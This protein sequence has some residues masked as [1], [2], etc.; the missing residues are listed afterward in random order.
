MESMA[1]SVFQ[2]TGSN[3]RFRSVINLDISTVAYRPL[4]GKSFI[5]LP[6]EL[7][8]KKAVIKMNNTD[9]HCFKWCV[10]RAKS[11]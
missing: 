7:A 1:V 11:C 8:N 9:S 2:M 5:P 10:T 4:R 3:W 6:K